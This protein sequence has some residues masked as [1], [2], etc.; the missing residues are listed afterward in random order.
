MGLPRP[1][2]VL[3]DSSWLPAT[4]LAARRD[5]E[6]WRGLVTY[7]DRSTALGYYHWRGASE[8][9][10][11]TPVEGQSASVTRPSSTR[12]VRTGTRGDAHTRHSP[13]GRL[14]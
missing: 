4:L 2:E 12:T 1:V 10:R 14:G 9:R 13:A 5:P 8:L 6:G 11:P 7:T 3:H